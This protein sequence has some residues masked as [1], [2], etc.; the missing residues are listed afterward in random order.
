[1]AVTFGADKIKVNGPKIDGTY[2]IIFE[3]GEYEIMQIAEII[4]L[5]LPVR[6]KVDEI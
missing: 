1:M 5:K 2:S 3:T 6:V 4:K